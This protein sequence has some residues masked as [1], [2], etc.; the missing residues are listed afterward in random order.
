MQ[1]RQLDVWCTQV[2]KASPTHRPKPV[3]CNRIC[4]RVVLAQVH[5]SLEFLLRLVRFPEL[6]NGATQV[7]ENN[8]RVE[9]VHCVLHGQVAPVQGAVP[10]SHGAGGDDGG[11]FT[12]SKQPEHGLPI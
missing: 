7:V 1:I 2:K 10:M 5:I 11:L 6:G 4:D 12:E 3:H 8:R 9:R